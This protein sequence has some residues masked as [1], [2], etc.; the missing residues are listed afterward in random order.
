MK[1]LQARSKPA[2]NNEQQ[3]A[4][5]TRSFL[6]LPPRTNSGGAGGIQSM[7][8][9]M[10]VYVSPPSHSPLLF[11]NFNNSCCFFNYTYTVWQGYMFMSVSVYIC[12]PPETEAFHFTKWNV[13]G[14]RRWDWSFTE[15]GLKLHLCF[16]LYFIWC[17]AILKKVQCVRLTEYNRSG[18]APEVTF[19]H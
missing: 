1:E 16:N 9:H 18:P 7:A 17:S 11:S 5:G 6:L 10:W 3:I 13:C 19:I 2:S 8:E 4:M 12:A 14:N 15:D